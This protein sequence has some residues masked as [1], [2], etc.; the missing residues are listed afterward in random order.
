MVE[1]GVRE[2]VQFDTVLSVCKQLKV[3]EFCFTFIDRRKIGCDRD[4]N[5]S[6]KWCSI[7]MQRVLG[8]HH[9]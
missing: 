7:C 2:V 8:D 9:C 6:D 1:G 4:H 3:Y 5:C